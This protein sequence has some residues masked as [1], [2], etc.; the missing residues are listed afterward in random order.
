MSWKKATG[1]GPTSSIPRGTGPARIGPVSPTEQVKG[2]DT[3]DRIAG[4]Q[5]NREMLQR[6]LP[7]K[8]VDLLVPAI[9]PQEIDPTVGL[10]AGEMTDVGGVAGAIRAIQRTPKLRGFKNATPELRATIEDYIKRFPRLTSTVK[11]IE[12]VQPT[13]INRKGMKSGVWGDATGEVGGNSMITRTK[14]KDPNWRPDGNTQYTNIR[15]LNT[16]QL[17]DMQDTFIHEL[18]HAAQNAFRGGKRPKI[19]EG[20]PM[21]E[22]HEALKSFN[23]HPARSQEIPYPIRPDEIS[24]R[25]VARGRTSADSI[26]K[27]LGTSKNLRVHGKTS[28]T[29]AALGEPGYGYRPY[30]LENAVRDAEDPYRYEPFGNTQAYR[31]YQNFVAFGP[32]AL[33]T[34]VTTVL[35]NMRDAAAKIEAEK[36]AKRAVPKPSP[37]DSWGY[38]R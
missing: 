4:N 12:L 31:D 20:L 27:L 14:M 32:E 28:L 23:Y 11:N 1:I 26:K 30:E 15:I 13:H 21:Y 29:E 37:D 17:S 5:A 7:D 3:F 19:A 6:F 22:N 33:N 10:T 24:A 18:T 2:G 38:K 36:A 35:Q 8:L 25:A 34:D 16:G 9:N